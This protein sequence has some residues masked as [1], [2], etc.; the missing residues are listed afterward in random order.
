MKRRL[1]REW[2]FSKI[3]KWRNTLTFLS[4]TPIKWG[5]GPFLPATETEETNGINAPTG[6]CRASWK[7]VVW[8]LPQGSE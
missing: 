8:V 7:T 3:S 5:A 6:I 4:R 2:V 1:N